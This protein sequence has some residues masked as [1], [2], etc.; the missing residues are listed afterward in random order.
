MIIKQ[1]AADQLASGDKP[2]QHTDIVSVHNSFQKGDILHVYDEKGSEIARGLTNF[3]SDEVLLFARHPESTTADLLGYS[4]VPDVIT[5][6]NLVVL[7][8]NHLSWD[9]PTTDLQQVAG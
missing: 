5:P 7:N 3:S 8:E 2:V 4:A 1:S 9:V 6:K